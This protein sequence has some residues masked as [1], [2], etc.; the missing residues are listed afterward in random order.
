MGT[1]L[2]GPIA[3]L[4]LFHKNFLELR[5]F[6]RARKVLFLG[7]IAALGY[8][9]VL[10]WL[11]FRFFGLEWLP[12]AKLIPPFVLEG[13][14][15]ASQR[16]SL[17]EFLAGGAGRRPLASVGKYALYGM[18]MEACLTGAIS[19]AMPHMGG[20]KVTLGPAHHEL[21]YHGTDGADAVRIGQYL[22]LCGYLGAPPRKYVAAARDGET[23]RLYFP[24]KRAAAGDLETLARHAILLH[25]MRR[26]EGRAW[27]GCFAD[28]PYRLRDTLC[29]GEAASPLL[30]PLWETRYPD[31]Q[32]LHARVVAETEFFLA[33][34]GEAQARDKRQITWEGLPTVYSFYANGVGAREPDGL[35]DALAASYGGREN[36]ELAAAI[37]GNAFGGIKV[38]TAWHGYALQIGIL[39]DIRKNLAIM[40]EP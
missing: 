12:W 35:D 25:E 21:Y 9:A 31:R 24:F 8:Y 13:V 29:F 16:T 4:I 23:W 19:R 17:R 28:D 3:G 20:P 7:M 5:A 34:F 40:V 37:L 33:L 39:R 15:L 6:D 36:A 1:A 38:D 10:A 14:L 30:A 32:S 22:E 11:S 26:L 18:I 27:R 2:G